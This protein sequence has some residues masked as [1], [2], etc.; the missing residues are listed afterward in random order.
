MAVGI[1][2]ASW[3]SDHL[4]LLD[5]DHEKVELGEAFS[6][7]GIPKPVTLKCFPGFESGML[8]LMSL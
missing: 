8:Q 3:N 5:K 4:L 6:V 1:F 2:E 7:P